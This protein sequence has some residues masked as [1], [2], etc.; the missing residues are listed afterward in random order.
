MRQTN[1]AAAVADPPQSGLGTPIR[2]TLQQFTSNWSECIDE[3]RA[4]M[5]A[6][7][8]GLDHT[9]EELRRKLDEV[10]ERE[11]A[12]ESDQK[13]L[14]E[15]EQQLSQRL[16]QIEQN[17]DSGVGGVDEYEIERRITAATEAL[18]A[19]VNEQEGE[20]LELRRELEASRRQN[21]RLANSAMDLADARATILE[22]RAELE[23]ARAQ[24]DD[25]NLR[26]VNQLVHE[27]NELELELETIRNRAAEL[28]EQGEE[29]RRR[30]AEERAHWSGEIRQ[31]RRAIELQSQRMNVETP[32]AIATPAPA[33]TT[34]AAAAAAGPVGR[35]TKDP[36]LDAVMAQ[37]QQ[38]QK[39]RVQRRANTSGGLGKQ[40]VA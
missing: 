25:E 8:D 18:D 22:L 20:L 36:V 19:R 31:L 14:L 16:E 11:A 3:F 24:A 26:R 39:E 37:F 2:A 23:Q 40:E 28:Q 13:S 30:M 15:L 38:L 33:P 35:A 6:Q 34:A 10:R 12:I 7:L 9:R 29:E 27:R 1:A 21:A 5:A 32:A 17:V 4:F